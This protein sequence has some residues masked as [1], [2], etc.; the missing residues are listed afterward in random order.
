MEDP[1]KIMGRVRDSVQRKVENK[2]KMFSKKL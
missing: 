2:I 1:R